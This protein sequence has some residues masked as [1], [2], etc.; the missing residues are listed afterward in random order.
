MTDASAAPAGAAPLA[1]ISVCLFDAYGTLF[2]VGEPVERLRADLG[3]HTDPL[4]ALW[5]AKQ[6]EYSWVRSLMGQFV[7]FWTVTGEAL[8]HA[9]AALGIADDL[10]RTRL[11]ESYLTLEAHPDAA[12]ALKAVQAQGCKAAILSNGSTMMLTSAVKTAGLA[13][14]LDAILSV[15]PVG[16]F[17]PHGSVYAL[18]TERFNV[19]PADCGFVSANGWDA[20][21][22][23]VFG[24]RV[25]RLNRTGRPADVL[26]GS[27]VA[28]VST[29]ADLPTLIGT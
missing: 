21:G 1:G 22:A 27:P 16:M 2:D 14:H 23:A 28:E 18:A 12:A 29:L 8:D 15:D 20:A 10:L 26:P 11:M 4:I 25:V 6:L 17:K 9:L 24:F 3:H 7:D 19:S 13:D 5:R